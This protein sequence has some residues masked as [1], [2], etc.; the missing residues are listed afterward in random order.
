MW[1]LKWLDT[2]QLDQRFLIPDFGNLRIRF[3]S[4]ML[5]NILKT[6]FKHLLEVFF[7]MLAF[8]DSRQCFKTIKLRF[9]GCPAR[10]AY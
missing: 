1:Y 6:K 5:E 2:M 9:S 10:P 3:W 8:K 7:T 4:Q